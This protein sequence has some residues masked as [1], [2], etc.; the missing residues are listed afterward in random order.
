M[1][2]K[3]SISKFSQKGN[4]KE[5]EHEFRFLKAPRTADNQVGPLLQLVRVLMSKKESNKR[6]AIK[7]N[8]IRIRTR[9]RTRTRT[10]KRE[11]IKDYLTTNAKN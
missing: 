4:Q 1:S 5:E 8:K 3:D 9:I 6:T 7:A 11:I 2:N 10:R